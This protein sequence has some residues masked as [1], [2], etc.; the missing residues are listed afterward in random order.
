VQVTAGAG[1]FI[2]NDYTRSCDHCLSSGIGI[3][4]RAIQ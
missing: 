2:S 1:P 4:P 3:L